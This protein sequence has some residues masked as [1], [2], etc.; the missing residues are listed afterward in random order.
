M[1][2]ES[3]L[4][5]ASGGLANINAQF[6]LIS[7]N[8]ANAATP[9]YAVEVSTQTA[10]TADGMPLGVRTGP[11]TL[12][13][14]QTLQAAS[15]QQNA[16]VTGL[17]TTQTALQ[18]IDAVL[19]TPGSGTDIGSLLGNLKN[20]FSTLLTDPGSQTQQSAV[21]S[22]AST[23]ANGIN[24]LSAAYTAQRQAAQ[25]DLGSAV[26]TLNNTLA[27]IGQLNSQI[28][29]MRQAGQ[30]TADLENQRNASVAALS[31]LINVQTV[32]QP[33]GSIDLYTTTGLSLPAQAGSTTGTSGPFSIA[34]GSAQPGAY[35]PG[36]GLPGIA[37]NGAD[38]TSQMQGGQ[39][40]AD[41]TL[42][43]TTLPTDQAELDEFS[44]G[45][46]SQFAAQGLTL[47]TDANGNVPAGGG[48]PAQSGYVGFAATIQVNP[49]VTA[50]PNLVRDGTTA[51]AGSAT[52][53]SAFTPNDPVTGQAGF[54][55][56]I[57][58]VL[59][60]TFGTQAQAGVSQPA[61]NTNGLGA[62]GTLTAPFT[63]PQSLSDYATDLV[64]TQA[65]TSATTTGNLATEQT[66]QSSLNARISSVSGV[67]MDTEM[68][69]M[70]GLQN[71]YGANARV[72][73]AVQA[74][75]QQLL[76]AVQ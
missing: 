74:M 3:A 76:Q 58:R 4:S 8:V 20:S 61:L 33:D 6:A 30:S 62:T 42:R 16:T 46:A 32:Q 52:G 53:A 13:I 9:S 36:G 24:S 15:L 2:L 7:Q 10:L 17:Q 1:S 45:L 73:A 65:Q 71:A 56:L 49:A 55:T 19:G 69:Q 12:Q 21:V 48:T 18:S 22:A 43:D 11:A 70:I 23:L 44:Y 60:Y 40:G 64:S 50:A 67:N 38:V 37:L 47:F 27:T 75:F 26:S 63:S 31:K 41:I 25:T 35:Y 72:I 39:I 34:G 54:T 59:N 51:I 29:T 5:I 66:M 68:S 28:V 57:N 14:D